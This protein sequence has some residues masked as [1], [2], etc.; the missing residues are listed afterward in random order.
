MNFSSKL[1]ETKLTEAD[2]YFCEKIKDPNI[3]DN[4]I[5]GFKKFLECFDS[6]LEDILKVDDIEECNIIIYGTATLENG[7]IIRAT[8]KYHKKPWFSNVAISM[9]P[10]ES[11]AYP[12]DEGLCFGKILLMTKI[13]IEEEQPPLNL[14]LVQWYN[15]KFKNNSYLY[16]CPLLKLDELYDLIPIE[17][18]DNIVHIIPRFDKNNEYFVNKYIS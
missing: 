2:I 10:D 3:N 4:M 17:T 6:F 13:E 11:L 16:N 12:S 1:F 18:I 7:S 5:K 14:A 15:F 8:S 9:D